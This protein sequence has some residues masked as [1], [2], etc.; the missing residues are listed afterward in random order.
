LAV[1][2]SFALPAT[3]INSPQTRLAMMSFRVLTSL[4]VR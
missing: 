1:C 4:S 2:N 3:R